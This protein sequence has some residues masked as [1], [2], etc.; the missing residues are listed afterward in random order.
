MCGCGLFSSFFHL[1]CFPLIYL[2]NILQ[3][4]LVVDTAADADFCDKS[5]CLYQLSEMSDSFF[6]YFFYFY[7]FVKTGTCNFFQVTGQIATLSMEPG[8]R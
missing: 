1:C 4:V 5:T 8:A 2:L 3:F 6:F 7:L